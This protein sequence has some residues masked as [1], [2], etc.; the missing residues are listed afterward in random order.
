MAAAT[1]LRQLF[2]ERN[3]GVAFGF[4]PTPSVRPDAS[5]PEHLPPAAHPRAAARL[6][7]RCSATSTW[8]TPPAGSTQVAAAPPAAPFLHLRRVSRD[9]IVRSTCA[10]PRTARRTPPRW[11]RRRKTTLSA[12]R[13]C[14]CCRRPPPPTAPLRSLASEGRVRLP[15]PVPPWRG[16]P[17][18][19]AR[20]ASHG[21]ARLAA[22]PPPLLTPHRP[23]PRQSAQGSTP[24]P[25]GGTRTCRR[26]RRRTPKSRACAATPEV[27]PSTRAV[28]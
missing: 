24:A 5:E 20:V 19:A 23:L 13:V 27:A 11:P 4:S 26:R 10:P 3:A 6:V 18:T 8:G 15:R 16:Q 7:I 14:A 9:D 21:T 12:P 28:H 17:V 22:T 2:A 25:S 1:L